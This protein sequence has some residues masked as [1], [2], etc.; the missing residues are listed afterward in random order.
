MGPMNVSDFWVGCVCVCIFFFF[1]VSMP[2][3]AASAIPGEFRFSVGWSSGE[4]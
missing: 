3:Y 2:K 4:I 1:S